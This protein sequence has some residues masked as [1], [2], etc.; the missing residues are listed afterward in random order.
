M[1]HCA[2]NT[3]GGELALNTTLTNYNPYNG[4]NDLI[5][6]K[7]QMD[8]DVNCLISTIQTR[9]NPQKFDGS[10]HDFL[11]NIGKEKSVEKPEDFVAKHFYGEDHKIYRNS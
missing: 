6:G 3:L 8:E 11:L 2:G 10:Y 9:V 1:L 5:F 7:I 4:Q